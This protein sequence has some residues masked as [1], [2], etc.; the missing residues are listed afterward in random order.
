MCWGA[1]ARTPPY[2]MVMNDGTGRLKEMDERRDVVLVTLD[3]WRADALDRMSNLLERAATDG[4]DR[5]EAVSQSA[6]TH[7][8]F[9]SLLASRYVVQAYDRE[10]QV[11]TGVTSLSQVFREHGYATGAVVASNPFLA[12]WDEHFHY[13]WNDGMT[14]SIDYSGP[15]Y[16]AFDRAQRFVRLKQRVDATEV[17]Q[18]AEQWYRRQDAPR[19]LWMH[20]MDTHGPYFPGLVKALDVGLYETYSTL[21][22]YHV[23]DDASPSVLAGLRELYEQCVERLDEQLSAVFEFIHPEAVVVVTGDHGEEFDHGYHGHAQLY[24]ECVRTPL[25]ARNLGRPV[26]DCTVRHLD[27]APTILDELGVEPP[28]DWEG[29]PVDGTTR[30][31]LLFNHA[32]LLNRTYVGVRT[33]RYK[34]IKS[35]HDEQWTV[36]ERELY[37][38]DADPDERDPVDDPDVAD[39]LEAKVDEFLNRD[40]VDLEVIRNTKSG[41]DDD[42]Q[43]RLRELGYL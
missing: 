2:K 6:A 17:A 33:E 29:A 10:G 18:R 1:V 34:F 37:D 38:L 27:L 36:Q 21:F 32:P 41:I 9:P 15:R 22:K 19:F 31:S 8:A 5:S 28:P 25:L 16:S 35:F 43:D 13:Y 4:Y 40:D 42:V 14:T 30:P 26:A 39:E 24:E 11:R 12:K 20:L 3:A 7:G 23:R